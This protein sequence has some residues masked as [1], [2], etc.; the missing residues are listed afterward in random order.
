M[1]AAAGRSVAA[2]SGAERTCHCD[3]ATPARW[4]PE[5]TESKTRHQTRLGRS[6]HTA[7]SRWATARPGASAREDAGTDA[8]TEERPRR[9]PPSTCKPSPRVAVG[10]GPADAACR[11]HAQKGPRHQGCRVRGHGVP[12]LPSPPPQARL[13]ALQEAQAGLSP[14]LAEE[15]PGDHGPQRWSLIQLGLG[16][17][18]G[19][20]PNRPLQVSCRQTPEL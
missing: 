18:P 11:G 10:P 1:A 8:G 20:H 12:P 13:R 17:L 7:S 16:G 5:G 19:G 15:V 6:A 4:G 14:P 2:P 9:E 3:P